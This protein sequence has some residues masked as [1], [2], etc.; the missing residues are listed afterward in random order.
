MELQKDRE[1]ADLDSQVVPSEEWSVGA[2]PG[3]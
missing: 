1:Q 2:A 3:L